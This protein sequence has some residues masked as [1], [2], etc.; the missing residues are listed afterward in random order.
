MVEFALIFPLMATVVLGLCDTGIYITSFISVQDAAR[1]AV[2]RNSGG[3]SSAV[4]QV[5]A[6][7]VA[8]H[9]LRGLPR[10]ATVTGCSSAPLI[11]TSEYCSGPAACGSQAATAD[12]EPAAL[13]TV[14]YTIPTAFRFPL[15]G[16]ETIT[17]ESQMKL[18]SYE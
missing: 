5:S 15:A 6:C 12:G 1:A 18:R 13:V 11:V 14:R 9:H 8:L 16:P 3:R 7:E 10:M 17:A 4:D 2:L